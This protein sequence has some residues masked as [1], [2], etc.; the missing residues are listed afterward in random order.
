MTIWSSAKMRFALPVTPLVLLACCAALVSPSGAAAPAA[1][2]AVVGDLTPELQ[3][4]PFAVE[5][6][7]EKKRGAA[8]LL[9]PIVAQAPGRL[10]V[11]FTDAATRE[12][13]VLPAP[14]NS[15]SGKGPF[16]RG[17][18]P[19]APL[20]VGDVYMLRVGFVLPEGEED[21]LNGVLSIRTGPNPPLVREVKGS[22]SPAPSSS[23]KP[24]QAKVEITATRLTP[25]SDTPDEIRTIG[26]TGSTG[27]TTV[28]PLAESLATLSHSGGGR[29]VLEPAAPGTKDV[30]SADLKLIEADGVGSA[31][32][33]LDLGGK[34]D[35]TQKIE[36]EV[37]VGDSLLIPLIVIALGALLR[38]ELR[39]AA[40]AYEEARAKESSRPLGLKPIHEKVGPIGLWPRRLRLVGR[41]TWWKLGDLTD[42]NVKTVRAVYYRLGR[43]FSQDALEQNSEEATELI[44]TIR[45]WI[46]IRDALIGLASALDRVEEELDPG[47]SFQRLL[48]DTSGMLERDLEVSADL[49]RSAK[50]AKAIGDQKT[51]LKLYGEIKKAEGRR[52]LG[53]REEWSTPE[54]I[55]QRARPPWRR[56]EREAETMIEQLREL[57][58]WLRFAPRPHTETLE[59]VMQRQAFGFLHP[60]GRIFDRVGKVLAPISA[61]STASVMAAVR[62]GDRLIALI[63]FLVSALVYLLPVYTDGPFGTTYDYLAAFAAGAGTQVV[64]N[65]ALLPLARSYKLEKTDKKAK[66]EV[67]AAA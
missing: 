67:A 61:P 57:L 20:K 11:E 54:V 21:S 31:T 9:I 10:K 35:A 49:E 51:A 53:D 41:P 42:R 38:D 17:V 27:A 3:A 58:A 28:D 1:S 44:G 40:E 6:P 12:Q 34:G 4:E 22:T 52:E 64:L 24:T 32:T 43:T 65:T 25:W 48:V 59:M 30:R 62:S 13:S 14:P 60:S 45:G 15:G 55:Y 66:A 5:L 36:V 63:A 16:L 26:L 56:S 19:P 33:L 18:L 8:P 50:L 29:V 46:S 39:K 23:L 7:P 47:D 37:E 2:V